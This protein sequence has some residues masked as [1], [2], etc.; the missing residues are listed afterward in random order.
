MSNILENKEGKFVLALT[1]DVLVSE[2]NYVGGVVGIGFAEMKD[3]SKKYPNP[4]DAFKGKDASEINF[5][6]VIATDSIQSLTAL[7]NI[8]DVTI[9]NKK[10]ADKKA[11]KEARK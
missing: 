3:A 4:S 1:G 9:A 11:R 7:R 6:L 10:H 2:I 8:I 5:E